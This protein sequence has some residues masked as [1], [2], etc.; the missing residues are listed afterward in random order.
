MRSF[1]SRNWRTFLGVP[2][3]ANVRV[4]SA[5]NRDLTPAVADG[6]FREDLFYRLNVISLR[7]PPLHERTGDLEKSR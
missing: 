1:F 5:T 7:L 4:V 2:R 6:K 3:R